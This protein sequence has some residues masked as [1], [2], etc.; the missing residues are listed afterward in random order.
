[1]DFTTSF[2]RALVYCDEILPHGDEII[3]LQISSKASQKPPDPESILMR[4]DD[5]VRLPPDERQ[6]LSMKARLW[7]IPSSPHRQW[8]LYHCD[9]RTVWATYREYCDVVPASVWEVEKRI[10]SERVT[11]TME[12]LQQMQL[13]SDYQKRAIISHKTSA[14]LATKAESLHELWSLQYGPNHYQSLAWQTIA[15]SERKSARAK[16]RPWMK[17]E[18]WE[19][20]G[21]DEFPAVLKAVWSPDRYWSETNG[22]EEGI[23]ELKEQWVLQHCY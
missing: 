2:Y 12:G 14:I 21:R 11:Q 18:F 7:E 10:V 6:H 23:D 4:W 1:M 8:R 5:L 9:I 3:E 19:S 17:E 13:C 16:R 15:G 20:L 22:L